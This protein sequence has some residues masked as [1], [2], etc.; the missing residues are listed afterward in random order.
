MEKNNNMTFPQV[1][2]REKITD[3]MKERAK[4]IIN[5]ARKMGRIQPHTAA[6]EKYPVV[7]E[8]HKGQ[9]NYYLN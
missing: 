4:Q 8:I 6:F 9:E 7:N 5:N 2:P 3:E 1:Q